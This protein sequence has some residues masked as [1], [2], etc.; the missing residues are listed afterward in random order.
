MDSNRAKK[1]KL[2]LFV[3]VTINGLFIL[4]YACLSEEF[5]FIKYFTACTH[6]F[7]RLPLSLATCQLSVF[8]LKAAFSTVMPCKML[9]FYIVLQ[10]FENPDKRK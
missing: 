4:I 6:I 8:T 9:N 7:L 3:M 2:I 10:V 1:V 5:T